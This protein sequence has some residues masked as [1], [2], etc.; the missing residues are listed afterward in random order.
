MT[1]RQ[2]MLL[3]LVLYYPLHAFSTC[4]GSGLFSAIKG[5]PLSQCHLQDTNLCLEGLLVLNDNYNLIYISS[6]IDL[7]IL[8]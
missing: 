5:Q 3:L 7:V 4:G 1:A 2:F 8:N 6:K